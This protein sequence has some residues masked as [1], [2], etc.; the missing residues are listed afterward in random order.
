[1]DGNR[2]TVM[3]VVLH[4]EIEDALRALCGRSKGT[5]ISFSALTHECRHWLTPELQTKLAKISAPRSEVYH[6]GSHSRSLFEQ[7]QPL[8]SNEHVDELQTIHTQLLEAKERRTGYAAELEE[9][10]THCAFGVAGRDYW[11][12]S[13]Y[14]SL[15]RVLDAMERSP[16]LHHVQEAGVAALLSVDNLCCHSNWKDDDE[17]RLVTRIF[18][19]SLMTIQRLLSAVKAARKAHP[20]DPCVEHNCRD[21]MDSHLRWCRF[22]SGDYSHSDVRLLA[23]SSIKTHSKRLAR[24]THGRSALCV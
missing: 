17:A 8:F 24:F 12:S 9:L 23:R 7:D 22:A 5:R 2:L 20:D 19:Y 10:C 14:A 21:I 13:E 4:G 11:R 18:E 15:A 16:Y 1:M 3:A 6:N